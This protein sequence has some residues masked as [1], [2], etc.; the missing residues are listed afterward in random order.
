MQTPSLQSLV[1]L[2]GAQ[3]TPALAF[4]TGRDG[5]KSL[6]YPEKSLQPGSSGSRI[7]PPGREA[8]LRILTIPILTIPSSVFPSSLFTSSLFPGDTFASLNGDT[9]HG[10]SILCLPGARPCWLYWPRG[11]D[12]G[13]LHCRGQQEQLHPHREP[14]AAP[15]P[16]QGAAPSHSWV[17]QG[18]SPRTK[19]KLH[20]FPIPAC[21]G[22]ALLVSPNPFSSWQHPALPWGRA[23]L[24][25]IWFG[26][27]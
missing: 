18:Q 26:L 27:E 24:R 20:H 7:T 15:A 4:Q 2:H 12:S 8:V 3:D 21:S 25:D 23:I 13:E 22:K 11:K 14:L 10:W 16:A 17:L 5:N 9:E 1:E 19:A 6:P